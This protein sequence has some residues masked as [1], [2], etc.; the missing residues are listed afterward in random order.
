[1]SG[2]PDRPVAELDALIGAT[3]GQSKGTCPF[4]VVAYSETEASTIRAR[5]KG[6]RHAGVITVKLDEARP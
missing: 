4:A 3:I 2:K 5:L 1:M 6:K